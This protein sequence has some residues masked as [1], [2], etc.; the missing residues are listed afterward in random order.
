MASL[1]RASCPGAPYE[2][3]G[4]PALRSLAPC[5]PTNWQ[6]HLAC[7]ERGNWWEQEA[8]GLGFPARLALFPSDVG[9]P[10]RPETVACAAGMREM[11]A[12][13]LPWSGAKA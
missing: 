12:V 1:L 4:F 11:G 6:S 9:E 7:F 13:E 3:R 10:C 5:W 8:G 2:L